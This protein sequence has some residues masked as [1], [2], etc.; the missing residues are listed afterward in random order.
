MGGAGRGHPA[1]ERSEHTTQGHWTLWLAGCRHPS[2]RGRTLRARHH[3]K[4]V[5]PSTLTPA[6]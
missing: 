6:P 1:S 3:S 2:P 5:T 4:H